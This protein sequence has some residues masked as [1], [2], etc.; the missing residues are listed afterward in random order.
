[1]NGCIYE[2]ASKED[3]RKEE[4]V[5]MLSARY[6]LLLGLHLWDIFPRIIF[7]NSLLSKKK[8]IKSCQ[9]SPSR[10]YRSYRYR[11]VLAIRDFAI[12]Q[13][14]RV[15]R[16]ELRVSKIFDS[17]ILITPFLCNGKDSS[18]KK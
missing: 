11:S 10:R 1:M 5:V 13:L 16:V 8:Q 6:R 9:Y 4:V 17:F 18:K 14:F 2:Y 15:T 3:D 12:R 7:N